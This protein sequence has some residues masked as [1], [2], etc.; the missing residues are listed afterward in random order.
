M[1]YPENVQ[2]FREL[3]AAMRKEG[4]VQA[5]GVVLGPK[6][7]R[8]QELENAETPE[9]KAELS[10]LRRDARIEAARQAVRDKLGVGDGFSLEY[11]DS[12]VDPAVFD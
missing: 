1:A 7:T 6:P 5:F 3:C 9:E 12:L 11:I 10:K 2:D 4:A 8:L